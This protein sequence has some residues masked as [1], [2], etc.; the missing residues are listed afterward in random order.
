M[1]YTKMSEAKETEKAKEIEKLEQQLID[2]NSKLLALRQ[3]MPATK[4]K[5]Y[6]FETLEGKV[7][8]LDL[9]AEK[10]VLFAIHNMGQACRYCTLW[11]DGFNPWVPH[12]EDKYAVV[13]LS[14]D[15]PAV[16]RRFANSRGWRFRM[17]SHGGK[18][19]MTEQ[20][21]LAD[22]K[23]APGLVVYTRKGDQIY[24]KNA[25]SFG[26][27]DQFCSMWSVLSLAGLGEDEWTPQ[28]RYWKNPEKMDD[29]GKDL[30]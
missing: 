17:A 2:I 4:V 29:G 10:E 8:L 24:R 9:F 19:Y 5:N 7:T 12:L 23:N 18:D 30:T 6:T 21:V 16:Q 26:P 1:R 27:G 3:K 25:T 14:K 22:M 11:A 15:A 13:L 20:G 28:Y